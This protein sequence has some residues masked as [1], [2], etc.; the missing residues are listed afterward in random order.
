MMMTMT[1]TRGNPMNFYLAR[2]RSFYSLKKKH[3]SLSLLAPA[4][5]DE[6]RDLET[7]REQNDSALLFFDSL[8]SS[9]SL[10]SSFGVMHS[11]SLQ[12]KERKERS[13][14]SLD[15]EKKNCSSTSAK[16]KEKT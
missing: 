1:T 3:H 12:R 11:S 9:S 15:L 2:G 10:S 14:F 16:N 6:E 8:S 13:N 5:R 4:E 7:E